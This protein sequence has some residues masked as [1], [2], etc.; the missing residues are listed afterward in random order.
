MCGARLSRDSVTGFSVCRVR[1]AEH[2]D[3]FGILLDDGSLQI[4]KFLYLDA[5]RR[6]P[7]IPQGGVYCLDVIIQTGYDNNV[8]TG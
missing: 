7:R 8:Y 4:T 6:M 5:M 1:R 3:Q 2:H